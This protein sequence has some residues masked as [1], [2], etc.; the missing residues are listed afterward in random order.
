MSEKLVLDWCQIK[1]EQSLLKKI[2]ET[3]ILID[4]MVI[5]GIVLVLVEN[6]M[7]CNWNV[8]GYIGGMLSGNENQYNSIKLLL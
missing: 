2:I 8:L 1:H 5:L 3:N 4:L 6:V 7:V